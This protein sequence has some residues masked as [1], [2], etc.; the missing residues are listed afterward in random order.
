MKLYAFPAN[1]T[2][3][4]AGP[5]KVVALPAPVLDG[6]GVHPARAAANDAT[7]ATEAAKTTVK[8]RK[9]RKV[10]A[11]DGSDLNG[12]TIHKAV[13]GPKSR[14][15]A[16]KPD[17]TRPVVCDDQFYCLIRIRDCAPEPRLSRPAM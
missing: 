16:P 10:V 8:A 6:P 9:L 11:P 13:A 14:C 12:G 15:E 2:V 17:G 4:L 7:V 1:A 5:Q 3:A